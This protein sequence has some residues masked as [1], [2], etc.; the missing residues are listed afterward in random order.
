M[1]LF[2][3]LFIIVM[4]VREQLHGLDKFRNNLGINIGTH[5][6]SFDNT[7]IDVSSKGFISDVKLVYY[8]DSCCV[9][10][11]LKHGKSVFQN[12]IQ[13]E[14]RPGTLVRF[15]DCADP[16]NEDSRSFHRWRLQGKPGPRR[17][18]RFIKVGKSV[19]RA[20]WR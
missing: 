15:K 17:L 4:K 10:T 19:P 3:Y 14:N 7:I 20:L 1:D 13:T 6:G 8:N 2:F 11:N 16:L 12:S 9:F 18:G 5:I